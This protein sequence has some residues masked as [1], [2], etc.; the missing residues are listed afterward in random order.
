[1]PIAKDE[2]ARWCGLNLTFYG[3]FV[4]NACLLASVVLFLLLSAI[5]IPS[6]PILAL[7]ALILG[8]A[9]PASNAV[10][11]QVEKRANRFT[12]AGASFVGILVAPLAI[13]MLN[14]IFANRPAWHIPPVPA[15]AGLFTAYTLG[16]GVG[17]LACISFGCCYGK[18]ISAQGVPH[19]P[20][21]WSMTFSGPTK[22]VAYE[23]GLEGR[24]IVPVQALTAV[25]NSGVGAIAVG[26]F[27]SNHMLAA[28]SPAPEVSR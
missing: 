5:G 26:L 7:A 23:G 24:P 28:G 2:G 12:V 1:V 3:V 13:L 20:L 14:Q 16:E 10:A 27:L 4:A 8:I 19:W 15:L 11:R 9:I 25:V 21:A 17:R 18:P 22:K 6:T